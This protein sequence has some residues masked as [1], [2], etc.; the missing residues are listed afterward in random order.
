MIRKMTNKYIALIPC[1]GK[2][3]RFGGAL[4]K[5]YLTVGTQT[6]LEHTLAAFNACELISEIV[7][8]VA[9]DD[10]LID[11]VVARCAMPKLRV[12][13]MGGQTRAH[14]VFNALQALELS[15]LDW[16]L[17][18][19]AVR[20]FI[21]PQTIT[22]QIEVL[23]NDHVG[24]ILAIPATDTVKYVENGEVDKTL[25][26][27]NIYLAQTPQMFRYGILSQALATADLTQ[28]TDEALAVEKLGLAVKIVLGEVTNIKITHAADIKLF[29]TP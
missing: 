11:D 4:P 26:R 5:Q 29:S 13:K 23:A 6:I 9:V 22:R 1:A 24:G 28:V 18:H 14:T 17:V 12:L 25:P 3:L 20:C 21:Q 10:V 19:D 15:S 8:V 27:Q 2:G 16:V 7:V